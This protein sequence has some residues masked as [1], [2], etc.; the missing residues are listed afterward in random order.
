MDKNYRKP[1]KMKEN[2]QLLQTK[3]PEKKKKAQE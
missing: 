2:N 1:A 3:G